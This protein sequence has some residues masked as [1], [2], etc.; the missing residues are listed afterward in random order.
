MLL[1]GSLAWGPGLL[2]TVTRRF[3]LPE[4]GAHCPGT[5]AQR[6]VGIQRSKCS[7]EVKFKRNKYSS[8]FW[9]SAKIFDLRNKLLLARGQSREQ[10]RECSR[11]R[12]KAG[13]VASRCALATRRCTAL[14]FFP[15]SHGH[16]GQ[17]HLP[18]PGIAS[19]PPTAWHPL[20]SLPVHGPYT[21]PS[22]VP[23]SPAFSQGWAPWTHH[24]EHSS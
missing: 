1:P 22:S 11:H 5:G 7:G 21:C 24:A 15:C 9:F 10:G 13:T 18:P 6:I 2:G 4:H 16:Q 12:H 20:G 14:S 23:K 17:R 3:E 8:H 19:Q